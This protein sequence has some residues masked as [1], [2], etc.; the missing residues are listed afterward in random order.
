MRLL[1]SFYQDQGCSAAYNHSMLA[2]GC[3]K[4]KEQNLDKDEI[5]RYF[6]CSFDEAVELVERGYITDIQSQFTMEKAK[7]YV[8]KK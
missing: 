2:L 1:A 6:E 5:I 3:K 7:P 8:Y 4:I